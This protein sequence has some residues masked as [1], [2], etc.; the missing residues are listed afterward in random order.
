MPVIHKLQGKPFLPE[1]AEYLAGKKEPAL[2]ILVKLLQK[3]PGD[4]L[5]GSEMTLA[6]LSAFY[7]VGYEIL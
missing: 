7:A 5:C 1:V 3:K 6:D 4:Y 2:Q